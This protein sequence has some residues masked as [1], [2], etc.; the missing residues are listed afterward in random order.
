MQNNNNTT[1]VEEWLYCTHE[2]QHLAISFEKCKRMCALSLGFFSLSFRRNLWPPC[3]PMMLTLVMS[4]HLWRGLTWRSAQS[5]SIKLWVSGFEKT[6]RHGARWDAYLLKLVERT[7]QD[8]TNCV[9]ATFQPCNR[10]QSPLPLILLYTHC[11]LGTQ[12]HDK[13]VG[14]TFAPVHEHRHFFF[15]YIYIY[16]TRLQFPLQLLS[17]I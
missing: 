17:L 3:I 1:L 5:L 4:H 13:E 8:T 9:N 16:C 11:I 10:N 12:D 15:I 2:D 7:W 14:I 6:S